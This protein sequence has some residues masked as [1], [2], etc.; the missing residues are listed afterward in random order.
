MPVRGGVPVKGMWG[1]HVWDVSR[2]LVA[3]FGGGVEGED[4]G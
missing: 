1:V 3:G 2:L 4:D